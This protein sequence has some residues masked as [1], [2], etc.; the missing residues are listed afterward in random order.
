MS[1]FVLFLFMAGML[2]ACASPAMV[3]HM[4][5]KSGG[6]RALANPSLRNAIRIDSISGGEATNPLWTSEV[7]NDDFRE[8]LA[9]SLRNAGLLSPDDS[10]GRYNLD[11]QILGL[12]QPAFGFD[13]TVT[14][15]ANYM[16]ETSETGDPYFLD[17]VTTAYTATVG[18]HLIGVERLRIANEGAVRESIREFIDRLMAFSPPAGR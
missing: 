10:T 12:S 14:C 13:M 1:K 17:T 16:V 5:V 9:A 8:A 2:S 18:S 7:S 11:V 3:E 6:E 4:T 15:H